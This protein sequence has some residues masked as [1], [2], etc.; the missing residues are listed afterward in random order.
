MRPTIECFTR[1]RN[2]K[3]FP[4]SG[5]ET[6]LLGGGSG[7]EKSVHRIA[8]AL[9]TAQIKGRLGQFGSLKRFCTAYRGLTQGNLVPSAEN[10]ADARRVSA[11]GHQQPDPDT[12]CS[13]NGGF[14]SR[15][16]EN[17]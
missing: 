1:I 5:C 17:A 9:R 15:K 8:A 13:S 11:V 7:T 6:R 2:F 12:G 10:A 4:R 14:W 16:V 3:M